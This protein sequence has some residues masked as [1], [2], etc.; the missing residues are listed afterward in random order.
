[1]D[2]ITEKKYVDL[3][4]LERKPFA[5]NFQYA[6]ELKYLPK[7]RANES[8]VLKNQAITELKG[9]LQTEELQELKNLKSLIFMIV[10]DDLE[11]VELS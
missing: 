7:E 10:G 11:M 6:I 1:M 5:V 9:Y 8:E 2:R 4:L 3:L